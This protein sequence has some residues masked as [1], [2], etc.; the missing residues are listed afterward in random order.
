MKKIIITRSQLKKLNESAVNIAA[1]SP[2]NS[3]P[4]YIK[5]ATDTDT[6]ADIQKAKVGSGDVN[7][8][9]SGA[10]SDDKQPVQVINVAKGQ[11]VQ[12]AIT[13]QGNPQL[14]GNGSPM[15][16]KGDGLGE[17]KVFTKKMVEEA[18]IDSM[19]KTGKVMTKKELKN[20]VK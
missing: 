9:V 7:L 2:D 14:T 10:D 15:L 16:I 13:D 8:F 18:R 19:R 5:A 3:I 1:T 20:S 6:N 4:A 12:K 17:S 11:T